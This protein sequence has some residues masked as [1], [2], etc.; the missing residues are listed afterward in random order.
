MKQVKKVFKI[1]DRVH[2]EMV[3]EGENY[4]LIS[5]AW[6]ADPCDKCCFQQR[7]DEEFSLDLQEDLL[8]PYRICNHSLFDDVYFVPS[9]EV[10][11]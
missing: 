9:V 8:N 5:N 4:S 2:L 11:K 7:C 3:F 6:D 1:T 10:L